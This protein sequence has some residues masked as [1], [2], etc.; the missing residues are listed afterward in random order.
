LVVR[1]R[2]V[3]ST[4]W[5]GNLEGDEARVPVMTPARRS[6]LLA[7]IGGMMAGAYLHERGV[8]D[9]GFGFAPDG[10]PEGAAMALAGAAAGYAILLA[11]RKLRDLA[12]R[13]RT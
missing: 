4:A 9:L 5:S 13:D 8:V 6:A 2:A 12:G 11:F 10:L 7:V 1:W 3:C